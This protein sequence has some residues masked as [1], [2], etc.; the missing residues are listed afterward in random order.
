VPR[1]LIEISIA[2]RHTSYSLW[3]KS[4]NYPIAIAS[5]L[6]FLAFIAHITGGV[7]Q[8]LSIA[9]AKVAGNHIEPGALEILDRNWV[10]AMCAFQL[11]TI[12]LLAL[13]GVL[14]LIGFTDVL[15]PKQLIA[16][17]LAAIYFLWGC[18][19][20]VQLFALRRR[21]KDYLFLGHWSFWFLCAGLIYWGALS[22]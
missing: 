6:T 18:S 11:V 20:L 19:W 17:G 16:F 21:P 22:L 14:Y 10:Q 4:L 9:P 7:K 12:D 13:S 5:G 8:S 3:R 15:A 1:G 2:D